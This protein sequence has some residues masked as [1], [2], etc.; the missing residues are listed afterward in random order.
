[1]F[2]FPFWDPLGNTRLRLLEAVTG[3]L[4]GRDGPCGF[5]GW[6]SGL[7]KRAM[8]AMDRRHGGMLWFR[9]VAQFQFNIVNVA[10]L[11]ISVEIAA[12]SFFSPL[13]KRTDRGQL[14][15]SFIRIRSKPH[16]STPHRV[17]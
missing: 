16:S 9:T 14:I 13:K 8:L 2:I 3:R 17:H 1:M 7:V 5:Q 15:S 12:F 4:R 11:R 10:L 6:A